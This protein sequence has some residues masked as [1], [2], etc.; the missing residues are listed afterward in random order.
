[1][2]G[3]DPGAEPR[4]AEAAPAEPGPADPAPT[5]ANGR[6]A[7][8]EPVGAVATPDSEAA[9][10]SREEPPAIPLGPSGFDKN[11]KWDGPVNDL[12]S[13][14]PGEDRDP[15]PPGEDH[16]PLPPGQDEGLP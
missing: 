7:V 12:L 11:G 10:P 6:P 2:R 16:N 5:A 15:L 14:E 13:G 9:Q 3:E 1:M 8:L 4:P